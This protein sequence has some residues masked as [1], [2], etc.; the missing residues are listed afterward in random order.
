LLRLKFIQQKNTCFQQQCGF[1]RPE[2][3]VDFFM[4]QPTGA[5]GPPTLEILEKKMKYIDK[6]R[7]EADLFLKVCHKL[8]R[9]M[10]VTGHGGNAAWKL[11]DN[12]ALITPTQMNKGDIQMEDLAFID[13]AGKQVEG[14]RRPTGETPMYVNF[15]RDRPDIKSVLHCHP[16]QTGA[17]AVTKSKNWLMRPVFPETTTE[18]GPVPVV[19]YG[20]PLTQRLADN[21]IPFVRK[22]NAFL[23][24]NHGLVIMS[25]WNI[26]WCM[27]TTEL[28]E[29]T[30]LS[31]VAASVLGDIKEISIPDLKNMDHIMEKRGLPMPGAPGVNRSLVDLYDESK[32]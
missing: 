12:L 20:E 8:S 16:P 32:K 25:P 30:S 3:R 2:N 17:F 29:M 7:K 18:V 27:M 19:P 26:E 24:E 22:Y 4:R 14:T 5:S 31:L 11:E 1:A 15:F 6:Y 13:M 9:L 28:L 21:F 23:M 10:Y